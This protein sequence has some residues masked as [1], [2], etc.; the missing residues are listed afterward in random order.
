MILFKNNLFF[1]TIKLLSRNLSHHIIDPMIIFN[2]SK[3]FCLFFFIKA[4]LVDE[5]ENVRYDAYKLIT[6]A[7]KEERPM[8]V[9]NFRKPKRFQ[10]NERAK[11]YHEILEWDLIEGTD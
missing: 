4:M 6:S 8:V 9:R 11:N 7:R 2:E 1:T 10:I 3:Y 5:A